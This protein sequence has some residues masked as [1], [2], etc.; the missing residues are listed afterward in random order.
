MTTTPTTEASNCLTA[1]ADEAWAAT[2]V[3]QPLYATAIGDRR[4]LETLPPNGPGA[5]DGLAA[6]YRDMLGRAE[7]IP[8]GDLSDGDRVTRS[9]LIDDLAHRLGVVAF[10]GLLVLRV[11][12]RDRRAILLGPRQAHTRRGEQH[13]RG[14]H[15]TDRG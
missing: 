12:R 4:F 2:M 1:L 3:A 5:I 7:A 9:A 13:C 14:Q 10:D 15:R 6:Q 11:E 8:A